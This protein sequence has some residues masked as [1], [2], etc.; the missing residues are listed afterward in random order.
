MI[1]EELSNLFLKRVDYSPLYA[2]V[3]LYFNRFQFILKVK[4]AEKAVII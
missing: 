4:K 2:K 1:S 3:P